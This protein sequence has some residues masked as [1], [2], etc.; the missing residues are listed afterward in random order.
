MSFRFSWRSVEVTGKVNKS[1]KQALLKTGEHLLQAANE[2]VPHDEGTL[3]RSGAVT[4]TRESG[5]TAEVAV[6]YD[7]P[8]AARLHEHPEYDFQQGRKGKW[9]ED[10]FK[11]RGPD[12]LKW[13]KEQIGN[14]LK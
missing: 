2:D 6:S 12:A 10:T 11:S 8:Y 9:L 3:M 14:D 7:T 13:L 5:N 1:V 4:V